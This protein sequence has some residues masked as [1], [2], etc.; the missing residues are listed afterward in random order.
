MIELLVRYGIPSIPGIW[1]TIAR[2]PTLMNIRSRREPLRADAHILRG[3]E[4]AVALVH[5]AVRHASQPALDAGPRLRRK[6]RPLL[7]LTSFMSTL[8]GTVVDYSGN[9]LRDEPYVYA[10][11]TIVFVGM[12]PVLITS[13]LKCALNDRNF[14]FLAP[15]MRCARKGPA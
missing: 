14:S 5:G 4:A 2:P 12:N 15:A 8:T 3:L 6:S 10:L 11:A 1:G 9:R 7:A 13:R